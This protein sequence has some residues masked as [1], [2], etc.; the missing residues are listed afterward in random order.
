MKMS[1]R[2]LQSA[3]EFYYCTWLCAD[4]DAIPESSGQDKSFFINQPFY[5]LSTPVK[6]NWSMG[7]V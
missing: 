4:S 7:Y 2:M 6:L 1:A 5:I 3:C